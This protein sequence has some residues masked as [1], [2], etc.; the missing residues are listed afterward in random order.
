MLTKKE[1][2][3]KMNIMG[4][5]TGKYFTL[6]LPEGLKP[7]SKIT[8]SINENGEYT[9]MNPNV[10]ENDVVLNQIVEDGY[11]RNS[12]LHRRFVMAQMFQMLN[13]VSYDGRD[14]GYNDYLRTRYGYDYT[15]KMMLE[16]VRVLSK[17][18]TRDKETFLEREHFFDRQ[19]VAKVVEDYLV[20]LKTYVDKLPVKNCKG[21]PYKKVKGINIFVADLDK[22][23]YF[24]VKS[25]ASQIRCAKDYNKVYYILKNFMKKENMVK[26]PY[27]TRKSKAWIDAYKGAGAYYTLKNLVMFHGCGIYTGTFNTVFKGTDAVAYLNKMLEAYK[28]EYYRM[29][30]LMK[31][32]IKD[33]NFDFK[34]RMEEIYNK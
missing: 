3:E 8:L 7:G 6:D 16:E 20:E 9:V 2:F 5:N 24:P 13:Y 18:E 34:K 12:K 17:L 11:V 25:V 32:V 29:F 28:G 22:K 10:T 26:L 23:L 33:N 4:V 31:K 19:T 30:A 14:K 21:V 27:D 1:R 15:L